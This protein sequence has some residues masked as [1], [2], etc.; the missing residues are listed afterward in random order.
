MQQ[1][2]A[3]M[4]TLGSR[5]SPL[6]MAQTRHVQQWLADAH[7][8]PAER[9]PITGFSTT[10]DRI[11][12][13]PL[14]EFG[15]KGLF[16]KELDEALLDGRIDAAIH[17]LKDLP[18]QLPDGLILA[19]V[20][21][22]EDVRDALICA[23]ARSFGDLPAGALIGSASLRRQAQ[24]LNRYPHLRVAPLRGSV[25]TRLQKVAD[26]QVAATLLALAGLKRLG[27]AD[28]AAAVLPEDEMLPAVGQG[29]LALVCRTDDARTRALLAAVDRAADH[30]AV[31]AE[32]AFLDAL[33]GSCRTPIAAYATIADGRLAMRGEVL[34]P[35][36]GQRW[37]AAGACALTATPIAD[38]E[39]LGRRIGA[40]VRAA[41]GQETPWLARAS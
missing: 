21:V 23:T 17:S 19:A 31:T 9:L 13:R 11:L 35:D 22:R 32:R 14:Y 6:A 3:P 29:A 28:A 39:A 20:P 2:D 1:A 37:Q 16:T 5:V 30:I 10:G 4:L 27:L 24:V 8:V 18:T 25:Q 26:G 15:G 36:G 40:E 38:A 12:D 34:T 7:G 33:D 41:A